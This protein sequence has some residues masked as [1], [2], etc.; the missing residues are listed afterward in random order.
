MPAADPARNFASDNVAGAS[1]E[2]LDA[3]IRANVDAARPYGADELS[4][5]VE[6]RLRA[7]FEHPSLTV[8]L[9]ASGTAANA[10]ALATLTPPWGSVLCHRDAHVGNDECGAPA[11]FAAGAGLVGLG[12]A[13]SRLDPDELRRAAGR[14][15]GDV[16][17]QQPACVTVTQAT[18]GGTVYSLAEL[19][20]IGDVCGEQRLRLHMDGARFANALVALDCTPAEMSWK[21]G[22]DIL[23]FGATKNGALGVEAIVCFDPALTEELH[24][25]RKRAGHLTSKMRFLAAQMDAYLAAD[26]WL[27]NARRANQMA[28]RLASGLGAIAGLELASP[29]RA[30]MLFVRMPEAVRV[31]LLEAG[32]LFYP[33]RRDPRAVRLVTSFATTPAA[34]DALLESARRLAIDGALADSDANE[35]Q[36]H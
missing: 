4:A 7:I 25:R 36:T 1:P 10:L 31:G 14:E 16:H 9:V 20:V 24:F 8:L 11:F 29:V 5:R 28:M 34:V 19:Q 12:G 3:L 2:I 27:R 13:E 32:F 22:V 26:L 6:Q 33:D 17:A 23:S 21:R 30:N 18:E 35:N 15:R